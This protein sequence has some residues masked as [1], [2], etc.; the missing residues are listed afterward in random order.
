MNMTRGRIGAALLL[1]FALAAAA[2]DP[3]VQWKDPAVVRLEVDFPGN[4]YHANWQLFRCLCG[5][6]LV[7]S[8]LNVPGETVHGDILLVGHRAALMRGHDEGAA[9]QV[10]L[11]A[12]ALMLQLTLRLLER[13]EPAG[14]SAVTARRKV[15]VADEI[16]HINLDTGAAAGGFPAPW[17]VTGEIA[18]QGEHQRTFDLHFQFTAPKPGTTD[19]QTGRMR[20]KGTADFAEQPFPVEDGMALSDWKLSWRDVNDPAAREPV[21]GTLEEL[22]ALLRD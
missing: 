13:A 8:E 11:D 16:N 3:A 17:S 14:P 5:D 12:P 10:S 22:R 7:R 9:E 2:L 4:G 18:P 15:S 19:T 20:L 6:L 1:G 21:P